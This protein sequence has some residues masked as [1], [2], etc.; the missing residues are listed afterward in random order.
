MKFKEAVEATK[1]IAVGY[2]RGLKGLGANSVCIQLQN[3]QKANGSVDIDATTK[4]LYPTDARWDYVIGYDEKGYFVEVHPANTSNIRE[5]VNKKKWL[6]RWLV[7]K[8]PRLKELK[9]NELYYWIPSGKCA[10]L[11]TSP[12]FKQISLHKLKITKNLRLE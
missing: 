2:C 8:A 7:E 5:M 3:A 11:P 9:A 12:Q 1:D 4:T 10:I 6:E